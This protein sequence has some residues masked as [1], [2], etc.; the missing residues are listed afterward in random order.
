MDT[1]DRRDL[2]VFPTHVGVFPDPGGLKSK[3]TGLPHARGGVS[4]I[5]Q[6]MADLA[7]VFP[8]HVGVFP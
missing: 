1:L 5:R 6:L 4:A 2:E 3:I 7:Q 8:T